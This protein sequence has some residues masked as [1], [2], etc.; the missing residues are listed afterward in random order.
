MESLRTTYGR[1]KAPLMDQTEYPKRWRH[2]I[3]Q[4]PAVR[5]L[6]VAAESARLRRQ[7]L[8]HMLIAHPSPGIGKTA[9]ASL[10]SSEMKRPVRLISG[11][12]TGA[13]ARIVLSEMADRDVLVIDEAHRIAEG[14]K[15]NAEWLLH[16]LQDGV[17]LGPLGPEVQPRITL[18][19][20]TTHP[21]KLPPAVLDRFMLV[22]PMQLYNTEEA[23]RIAQLMGPRYLGDS[24]P[25]LSKAEATRIASAAGNNPRSIKR[26]LMSLRDMTIT[27]AL[28][29]VKDRYDIAGLLAWHGITEDG[30]SPVAQQYLVALRNDFDGSA[31]AKA[32]EE[33]LQQ[34]GGLVEVERL[35][36]DRGLL[37]RTK[38]G[39]TLTQAGVTRARQLAG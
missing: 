23:A 5:M 17:L 28:P 19:A 12:V 37:V 7:P 3:G 11:K 29:L 39:R 8:D 15:A 34:P 30:L 31:G 38:Q 26:M 22:P 14:N 9:L 2:Y 6:Q 18:I 24:L 21:Q 33:R 20:V 36:Q 4:G 35:L 13:K 1:K 25:K 27:K 32:L 16:L 10:V